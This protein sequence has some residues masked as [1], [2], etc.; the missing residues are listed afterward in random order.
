MGRTKE[1]KEFGH[2]CHC[3]PV[4]SAIP[5][6]R[7]FPF[8]PMEKRGCCWSKNGERMWSPGLWG[9][10]SNWSN[11]EPALLLSGGEGWL[12]WF[13]A[14][15]DVLG[16]IKNPKEGGK[17]SQ[18]W[19]MLRRQGRNSQ[20]FVGGGVRVLPTELFFPQDIQILTGASDPSWRC[21]CPLNQHQHMEGS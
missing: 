10:K 7:E 19:R 8:P 15:L 13:R 3:Y 17:C 12:T 14:R 4:A 11:W 16:R 18:N 20:N 1:N 2:I 6:R 5:G 21:C 9:H